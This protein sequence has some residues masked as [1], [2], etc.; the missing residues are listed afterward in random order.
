MSRLHC[1]LNTNHFHASI[2]FYTKLL[3]QNPA[4]LEKMEA[5]ERLEELGLITRLE[6]DVDCCYAVQDKVWVTDPNGHNWEF[7]FVKKES[8]ASNYQPEECYPTDCCD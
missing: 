3:G 5:K 4:K 8:V 7:F 6:E 2:A 1:A